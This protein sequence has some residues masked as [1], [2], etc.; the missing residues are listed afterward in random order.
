M[1]YSC[2][3]THTEHS[4]HSCVN[5]HTEST[6]VI[7][8]KYTLST[9]STYWTKHMGLI[10]IMYLI[11]VWNNF[12]TTIRWTRQPPL[13]SS[14]TTKTHNACLAGLFYGLIVCA[15]FGNGTGCR[16]V[17]MAAPL[18]TSGATKYEAGLHSNVLSICVCE[19]MCALNQINMWRGVC[20][21]LLQ[22]ELE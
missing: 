11:F 8:S 20:G 6:T 7:L 21:G 1:K 14:H 4:K 22:G 16:T 3:D 17:T 12:R 18:L 10:S 2:L 19:E 13:R 9:V 5:T 15:Q